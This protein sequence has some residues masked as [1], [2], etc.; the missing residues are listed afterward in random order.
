MTWLLP[1]ARGFGRRLTSGSPG[2]CIA[3]SW[4]VTT[5]T[6]GRERGPAS[7]PLESNRRIWAVAWF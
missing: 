1:W 3:P 6:R 7:L 2:C 5:R 4:A